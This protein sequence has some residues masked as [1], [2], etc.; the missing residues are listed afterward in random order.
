MAEKCFLL[1]RD[2]PGLLLVRALLEIVFGR[3]GID[4]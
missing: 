2:I 3:F 1:G 4:R